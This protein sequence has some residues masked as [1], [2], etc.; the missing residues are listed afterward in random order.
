MQ[1][2]NEALQI[3][4]Q[5]EAARQ[6][7]EAEYRRTQRRLRWQGAGIAA[8]GL[9]L[10]VLNVAFAL[11]AARYFVVALWLGPTMFFQG[12]WLAAVGRPQDPTTGRPA[13]WGNAG[14]VVA[15]GMGLLVSAAGAA[16]L[17]G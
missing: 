15:V 7:Y 11:A 4:A 17:H 16:L 13:R 9:G 3:Q 5:R 8:V 14:L 10:N 1:P 6:R 2:V 12:I